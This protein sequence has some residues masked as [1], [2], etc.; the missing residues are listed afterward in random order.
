MK[1]Y[2][3]E[4]DQFF[5]SQQNYLLIEGLTLDGCNTQDNIRTFTRQ[6]YRQAIELDDLADSDDVFH[7]GMDS[8][9][10]LVVVQRF[11]AAVTTIGL[12]IKPE[13]V[14]SRLIYSASTVDK[15]TEAILDLV[16][17]PKGTEHEQNSAVLSRELRMKH[18]LEQYSCNLPTFVPVGKQA[19]S[20]RTI[21]LTGSTGSLGSYILA[22]LES[23]PKNE[24]DK[25][26]CLNRSQNSKER[27][28]KSNLDRGV[29]IEWDDERIEFLQADLSR[30]DLG[31]GAEKHAEILNNTTVIIHNAWQVNFNLALDSFEPQIQG[32]R[33]LLEFS[34]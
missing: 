18:L 11:R 7:R 31:L 4:L 5:L 29:N 17:K 28:R 23:L 6:I 30:L 24:D 34:A 13:D 14:D 10:V 16:T 22:A 20:L 19:N 33:N 26:Y 8:L 12:P 2:S 25:F 3:K 21:L 9:K 15:M 1:S 27:Q 32:V